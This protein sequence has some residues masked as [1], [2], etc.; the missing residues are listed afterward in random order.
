[1]PFEVP[2]DITKFIRAH[3]RFLVLGHR[4]PDGD[5]IASQLVLKNI[6]TS[7]G[8]ESYALSPGPFVRP[9][10]TDLEGAFD[11]PA[12]FLAALEGTGT[13]PGTGRNA[14]PASDRA[15][16][17]VDSSTPE[18]LEVLEPLLKGSSVAVVDHHAAGAPF[19]DVRFVVKDAPSTTFLVLHIAR[20]LGYTLSRGDAELLLF[21]LC[22]DTGFFRHVKEHSGSVFRAV[23]ELTE[24]GASPA[25]V[26]G[27]MYGNRV[28]ESRRLLGELLVRTSAHFGGRL[29]LTYEELSDTAGRGFVIRDSDTLYQLL[30]T[31][32]GAEVVVLLREEKPG[33]YSV[34]LRSIPSVDVGSAARDFGGGGHTQASGFSRTGSR[35]EIQ[36][37][38][39]TYF[40]GLLK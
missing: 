39:L 9:E 31:T 33:E 10:I 14:G 18:R 30:Q 4:E 12:P 37:E 5:C 28:L 32:R 26:F 23:A 29:L 11:D 24:A 3:R 35:A 27:L 13:D 1:M 21:G 34:G 38:I 7:L 2:K 15:V 20:E 36:A 8:K 25:K 6:L 19:G 22:T 17:V 16:I 40:E